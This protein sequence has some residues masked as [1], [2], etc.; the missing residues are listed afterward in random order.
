[1]KTFKR[2]L[3]VIGGPNHEGRNFSEISGLLRV[4]GL[5]ML[6]VANERN[7]RNLSL[8]HVAVEGATCT[9]RTKHE[10]WVLVHVAG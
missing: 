3:E 2:V 10:I 8:V 5:R 9:Q 6:H 1:L 4:A 7:M